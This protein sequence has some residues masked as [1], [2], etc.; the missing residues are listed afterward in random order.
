MILRHGSQSQI[1]G[2]VR[3]G[4][5]YVHR[6]KD[7]HKML[8]VNIRE[9]QDV[10]APADAEGGA[11]VEEEGDI[12]A[13]ARGERDQIGIGDLDIPEMAQCKQRYGGVAASSA[14]PRSRRYPLS[15]SYGSAVFPGKR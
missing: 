5:G 14:K 7:H 4:C 13:Q 1:Q 6:G 11:A 8:R 10:F 9:R 15:E 3:F 12:G 2:T